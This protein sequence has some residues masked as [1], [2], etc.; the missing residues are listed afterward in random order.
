MDV[1]RHRQQALSVH[2]KIRKRL[3]VVLSRSMLLAASPYLHRLKCGK[4]GC[5]CAMGEYRHE[6]D[7]VSYMDGD[8][9]RT[10]VIPKGM[11]AEVVKMTRAHKRF[12]TARR[13]MKELFDELLSEIDQVGGYRCEQGMDWFE[14]LCAQSKAAKRT[15]G[16]EP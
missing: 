14:K 6:M 10:R 13:E 9:S 4:P 16:D 5:K 8:K 7:C 2:E 15:Q 3:D 11:K 1:S 12:K